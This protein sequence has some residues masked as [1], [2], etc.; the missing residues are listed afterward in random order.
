MTKE[1]YNPPV[2]NVMII[3]I[4]DSILTISTNATLSAMEN[5]DDLSE[6]W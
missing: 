6:G 5:G 4:E 1:L 2:T 3:R